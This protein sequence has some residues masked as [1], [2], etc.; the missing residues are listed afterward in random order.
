MKKLNLTIAIILLSLTTFSQ[1][2]KANYV[3]DFGEKTE[4]GY[5]YIITSNGSFSNSA[6]QNAKLLSKFVKDENGLL[7]YVYEYGRSLASSI[8]STTEIVKMKKPDGQIIEFKDV[9]FTKKGLLLFSKDN[10]TKI[11]ENTIEKGNYI[12]IFKRSGKYSESSYK[13]KF[14]I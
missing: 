1:W 6:T 12:M 4:N 10:F 11:K 3:D 5:E 9:Y 13:I 7:I 14:S 8:E 2:K